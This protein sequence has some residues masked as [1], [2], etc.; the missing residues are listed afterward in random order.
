MLRLLAVGAAL[1]VVALA[2]VAA[3]AGPPDYQSVYYIDGN[4][5]FASC[6]VG[7]D[8]NPAYLDFHFRVE[9]TQ[10]YSGSVFKLEANTTGTVTIYDPN[11]DTTYTGRMT[12]HE[13]YEENP[14]GIYAAQS[15]ASDNV[16]LTAPD[17][18][19]FTIHVTQED[20]LTPTG[21]VSTFGITNCDGAVS[22]YHFI[23]T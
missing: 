23:F 20:T 15:T 3:A 21:L 5:T 16:V 19:H 2:P 9:T 8:S 14:T 18:S 10:M 13:V 12:T 1:G 17:G 4:D 6:G 22:E 11:T 7:I